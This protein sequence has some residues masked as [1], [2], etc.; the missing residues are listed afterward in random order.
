[1]RL[2]IAGLWRIDCAEML[3]SALGTDFRQFLD[4]AHPEMSL[5]IRFIRECLADHEML[6]HPA[7]Q[8]CNAIGFRDIAENAI[9]QPVMLR[10][11]HCCFFRFP[12]AL[13]VE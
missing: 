7:V 4:S 12:R 2:L 8:T 3:P 13:A 6:M 10:S 11:N 9:Q 5:D 1:L